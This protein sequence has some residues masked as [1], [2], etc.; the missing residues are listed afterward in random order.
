MIDAVLSVEPSSTTII[1]ISEGG[2]PLFHHTNE[3]LLNI[4][5][6]VVCI[7]QHGNQR[8][9]EN[10]ILRRRKAACSCANFSQDD[11]K[12]IGALGLGPA[13]QSRTWARAREPSEQSICLYCDSATPLFHSITFIVAECQRS[14]RGHIP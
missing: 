5:L 11:S 2:R 3:G 13:A 1:S 12:D 4:T 6:V 10:P 14:K 9:H 8:F 7:D